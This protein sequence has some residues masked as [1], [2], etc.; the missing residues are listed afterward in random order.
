MN[1]ILIPARGGSKGIPGKNIRPLNGKPLIF[2]TLDVAAAIEGDNI[3]CVSTDD[4]AIAGKVEE[5][6]IEIPFLRPANLATDT[7]GTREV[8]L[9]A[10]DYYKEQGVAFKSVILLQP[11]SPLRKLQHVTDALSLY[12]EDIDMVVS[13]TKSNLNPWYNLYR[14]T[15]DGYLVRSVDSDFT[16]RQDCPPVYEVNGAVYIINPGSIREREFHSFTR[17]VKVEMERKYSVDIDEEIDWNLAEVI[18]KNS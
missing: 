14:E 3:I 5:Y 13:V 7:S 15:S 6:G 10:L 1:L 12:T 9:H 11:T 2:Y 17:I 18:I 4:N 8:I 16:R